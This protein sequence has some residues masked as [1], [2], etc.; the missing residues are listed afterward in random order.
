MSEP[1]RYLKSR[2]KFD[3]SVPGC[4]VPSGSSLPLSPL[5]VSYLVTLWILPSERRLSRIQGIL[6][7]KSR[8]ESFP[9][10][11]DVLRRGRQL[12]RGS[13]PIWPFEC[14]MVDL[15]PT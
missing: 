15:N 11:I 6:Y 9:I 5:Q 8:T 14:R 2:I 4:G 3:T 10:P 1:E 7:A 13:T 12:Y